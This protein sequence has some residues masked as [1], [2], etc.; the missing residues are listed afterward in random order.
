MAAVAAAAAA[1]VACATGARTT[2]S[3]IVG[4][5][6]ETARGGGEL[7]LVAAQLGMAG[8]VPSLYDA[9]LRLRPDLVQWSYRMN[10]VVDAQLPVVFI[11]GARIG[12]V[13]AL[14][15]IPLRRTRKVVFIPADE[16]LRRYGPAARGGAILVTSFSDGR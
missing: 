3:T 10:G 16:A 2:R 5:P 9:L 15:A 8:P 13:D 12:D 7:T 11:D 4:T 1:L 14:R 6:G